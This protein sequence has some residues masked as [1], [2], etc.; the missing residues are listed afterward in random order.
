MRQDEWQL[1]LVKK[2]LKKKEKISLINKH[3]EVKSHDTLLDL[4][5]AQGI[6]SHFLRKKGGFWVSADQD[7]TN[8]Q[9]SKRLLLNNLIQVQPGPL[10]FHGRSFDKV[11]CLDYLEHLDDD[12]R[13]VD[14]IHRILKK[15]GEFIAATPR[16]GNI[17]VLNYL[18]DLLGMKLEFYGHKRPGYSLKQLK[19]LL[20]KAD[21]RYIKHRS[22]SGFFTELIEL[23]L[24][25]L[26]IKIFA[27]KPPLKLRDGN[28]RPST[29]GEFRS[30]QKAFHLYSMV[31]PVI[32]LISKIDKIFFFQRGYGI[33]VWAKKE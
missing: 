30:T 5:C 14:E 28:I 18:R 23:V 20:N 1:K 2:S 25:S 6:L 3:L 19:K 15:G 12:Q 9:S 8:V 7:F 29:S 24:N 26:Y 16:I 10:P 13:C 17:F 22:F 27:S 33:M 11:V 4:G 32:W 21:F 31:Y